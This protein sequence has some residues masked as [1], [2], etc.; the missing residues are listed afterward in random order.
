MK[1]SGQPTQNQKQK[2]LGHNV[3]NPENSKEEASYF[4]FNE[5][6]FLCRLPYEFK[7]SLY[8][9]LSAEDVMNVSQTS[10]FMKKSFDHHY[11]WDLKLHQDFGI[12][13]KEH[14]CNNECPE[15]LNHYRHSRKSGFNSVKET[16]KFIYD[17]C[18]FNNK[19]KQADFKSLIQKDV[20]DNEKK[21]FI[22]Q[23]DLKFMVN[24]VVASL[25]KNYED[26]KNSEGLFSLGIDF[27]ILYPNFW[28]HL[29]T[30][31]NQSIKYFLLEK[32]MNF[33]QATQ[34]VKKLVDDGRASKYIYTAF[35]FKKNL[36]IS[37]IICLYE[38]HKDNDD[39][40]VA[41]M[42]DILNK[43]S[44]YLKAKDFDEIK[45][46][47][48]IFKYNFDILIKKGI[49]H[50]KALQHLTQLSEKFSYSL[51]QNFDILIEKGT[52]T[53]NPT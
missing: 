2:Q 47:N 32:N 42:S 24:R 5:N 1:I 51:E 35:Y 46:V 16:Y 36:T 44:N 18:K 33:E 43:Y 17:E 37:D 34:E 40:S 30:W 39:D 52:S 14:H 4:H 45:K 20:R 25:L 19:Y 22:D 12:D 49:E 6:D 48:H 3:N 23:K 29:H 11:F 26:Y 9:M 53:L 13:F 7:H 8:P 27:A 41:N 28:G 38:Q 10:K 15:L 50:K 31:E 21:D